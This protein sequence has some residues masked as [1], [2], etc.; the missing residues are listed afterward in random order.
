MYFL[1]KIRFSRK[2]LILYSVKTSKYKRSHV[3]N[4]CIRKHGFFY[5]YLTHNVKLGNLW[6]P[7][8]GFTKYIYSI[9]NILRFLNLKASKSHW[10]P[11]S[12]SRKNPEGHKN[13]WIF[14]NRKKRARLPKF[15]FS[16][17]T[18]FFFIICELN[19]E[20]SI[21]PLFC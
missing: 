15:P 5:I 20:C 17:C 4:A 10:Q 18:P 16:C 2:S 9:N 13:W 8:F 19:Y 1:L 3:M 6:F 11:V 14:Q 7:M 12:K 21:Y